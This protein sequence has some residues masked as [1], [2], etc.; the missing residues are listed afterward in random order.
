MKIIIAAGGTGGHLFPGIAIA[1][2]VRNRGKDV[3]VLFVITKKE[4]ERKIVT[5]EGFDCV[6][7]PVRGFLGKSTFERL[8]LPVFIA[9]SMILFIFILVRERPRVIV[10][11]GGYAAFVPLFSGIL[12]HLPTIISEQDSYP[13]LTTRLLARYVTEVHLANGRA[14][15]FLSARRTFVMGNPLR[16]SIFEGSREEGLD[17]F[18]L[19]KRK[20]TV[21]ILGGSH[22]ARS[23]NK[24]FVEVLKTNEFPSFQ[25]IFQTGSMDHSWVKDSL[26]SINAVVRIFPFI[27]KMNLAY[28]AADLIFSRAGALTI[29]EVTAKGVPS[30]LI[31][32]PYSTGGHQRENARFLERMGA[33]V[34]VLDREL[35]SSRIVEL[36]NIILRDER[37]LREMSEKSKS[38]CR[39]DAAQRIVSR[40]LLFTRRNG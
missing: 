10:G 36:M 18:G 38:L 4:M 22:G 27:E 30:V 1:H 6:T 28:S 32:F 20:K 14:E 33:S 5:Q 24:A 7:L 21:F 13:G 26:K 16:N 11:T 2:E 12:F 31:P 3:D 29:A 15:K 40:I 39:R 25:F 34:M 35:S 17:Y 19:D 9:L 8:I 23:L 37:R